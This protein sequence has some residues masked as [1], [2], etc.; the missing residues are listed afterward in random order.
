MTVVLT[1]RQLPKRY[2]LIQL[3][4]DAPLPTWPRG[5]FM[6]VLHSSDEVTVVAEEWSV[7]DGLAKKGLLCCLEIVGPFGLDSVGIVAAATRPIAEAQISL[8][9]Y[10]TWSTDFILLAEHDL[11]RA[12]A[13]L[14]SAGHAVQ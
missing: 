11:D 3:P 10:S 1:L 5:R 6:A 9:V 2:A 12:K 4:A 8:F 14:A 7:P 13:A